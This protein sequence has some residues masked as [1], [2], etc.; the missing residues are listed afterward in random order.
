MAEN[1]RD[2][3]PGD[4]PRSAARTPVSL[5][6]M[7]PKPEFAARAIALLERSV[8]P[9]RAIELAR[10][11]GTAASNEGVRAIDAR[12]AGEVLAFLSAV[13]ALRLT[14]TPKSSPAFWR[15]KPL[16][17]RLRQFEEW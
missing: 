6:L 14:R 8:T 4:K 3:A 13:K 2:V 16:V 11:Y 7:F 5:A 10:S 17:R 9:E 15:G 1:V 12:T